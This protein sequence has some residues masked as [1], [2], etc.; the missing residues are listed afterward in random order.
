[1][2]VRLYGITEDGQQ[3]LIGVAPGPEK[4]MRFAPTLNESLKAFERASTVDSSPLPEGLLIWTVYNRPRD[5]P[6]WYVARMFANDKPTGNLLL[7][8]D[9]DV[10][11]DE[12]A[13]WGLVPMERSPGD[14][15]VILES[16]L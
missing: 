2:T 7:C 6:S 15:P 16:W 9:I 8:R 12:L 14:D 10:L 4:L 5:W 13:G 11:R 3:H 1:M